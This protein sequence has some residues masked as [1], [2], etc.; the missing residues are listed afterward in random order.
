MEKR[1]TRSTGPAAAIVAR[2]RGLA[3]RGERRARGRSRELRAA[4]TEHAR[5]TYPIHPARTLLALGRTQRRAKKR[6]VARSTL[7]EALARFERLGAPLW[8]DQT[9]AE[10]ARIGGRTPSGAELTEGEPRIAALVAEGKQ[11]ARS[12]PP[13][14]SPCTA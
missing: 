5:S 10:P 7:E 11:T 14:F 12:R 2:C 4:L 8:A 3:A 1:A 13:S 9:R 6:S